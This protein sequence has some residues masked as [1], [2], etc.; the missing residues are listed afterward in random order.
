VV[1]HLLHLRLT[2]VPVRLTRYTD[3]GVR[4]LIYLAVRP[5]GFGTVRSIADA[6]Q[7]SR[8]HLM[9][10]VQELSRCGYVNTVRGRGGG[11]RL[12]L[13]PEC[14]C[15][16]QVVRDMETDLEIVEC[17]GPGN[18]CVITPECTLK[19]VLAESLEAFLAVLDRYTLA[20]L[21]SNAGVLQRLLDV[22]LVDQDV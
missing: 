21:V 7:I 2:I 16:G 4:V 8:N 3:Y 9:K 1:A 22:R 12:R 14:I 11:I 10:V 18:R 13:K 5:D 15:V 20:D 6:Y 19:H 17:F